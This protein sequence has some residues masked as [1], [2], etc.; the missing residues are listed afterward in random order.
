MPASKKPKEQ[1]TKATAETEA[2]PLIVVGED[3]RRPAIDA[4]EVAE[5]SKAAVC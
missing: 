1:K 3:A 4:G 2:S 5:R